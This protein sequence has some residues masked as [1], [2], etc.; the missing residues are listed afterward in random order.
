M[1]EISIDYRGMVFVDGENLGKH[2]TR[3]EEVVLRAIMA[4]ER[5]AN[6]EFLL[7]IIYGGRDEPEI[8]ILDV[9]V[10]KL[11][12]KL[13][14]HRAAIE[15][16]WGRGYCRGPGYSIAPEVNSI[17]ISVDAK[18]LEEVVAAGGGPPEELV[19]RLLKAEYERLWSEAA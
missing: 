14:L 5:V 18:L 4:H 6:R 16:V 3:K 13:G 11:R 7:N 2:L 15:T 12:A 8:K 10:T 1:P 19:A 17:P 9:F